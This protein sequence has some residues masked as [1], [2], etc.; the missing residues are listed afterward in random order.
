M[1]RTAA[2]LAAAALLWPGGAALAHDPS[3]VRVASPDDGATVE[4]GTVDVVLVGE[5]GRD[6]ATFQLHLDGQAV[7]AT[8]RVGGVFTTLTV[9]PGRQLTLS[10][11]VAEGDHELRVTPER[12]PDGPTQPVVAIRFR[13]VPE[14]RGNLGVVLLFAVVLAVAFVGL[15]RLR[16]ARPPAGLER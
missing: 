3:T 4:G 5:G 13:A 14:S 6:A 12:N 16:S 1:R 15:W 2:L 7:D 10:V 8:G 9:H 11:P